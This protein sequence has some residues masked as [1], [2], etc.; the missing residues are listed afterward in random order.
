M[1]WYIHDLEPSSVA[2]AHFFF[3]LTG[4]ITKY[5]KASHMHM[6]R[7][8]VIRKEV[9]E[10]LEARIIAPSSSVWTFSVVTENKK[11]GSPP[12]CIDCSQLNGLTKQERWPLLKIE[13]ILE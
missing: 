8:A 5:P 3:D 10:I 1:A 4:D 11:S 7:N 2:I 9:N 13:K 6:K 12:L